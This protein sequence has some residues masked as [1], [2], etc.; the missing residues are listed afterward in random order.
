VTAYTTARFVFLV[1]AFH[2]FVFFAVAASILEIFVAGVRGRP[3]RLTAVALG[4]ALTESAIF[5]A[6]GFRCPLTEIVRQRT[7]ANVRV[8][9]IFLPRWLAD[10][11]PVI[12][13]PPLVIGLAGL[14]IGR[15]RQRS[16][17]QREVNQPFADQ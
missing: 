10:R 2:S 15:W 7:G 12:F 4:T 5:A 14:A 6:N 1:K 3:R 8:T 11:I 9:D 13:T 17:G 16:D